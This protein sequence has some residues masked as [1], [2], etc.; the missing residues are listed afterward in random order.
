MGERSN[1]L[2][3][4]AERAAF[5]VSL[6]AHSDRLALATSPSSN[7]HVELS[8]RRR[9]REHAADGG[10]GMSR[11][12]QTSCLGRPRLPRM[13]VAVRSTTDSTPQGF[14]PTRVALRCQVR[15]GA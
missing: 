14:T 6:F 10:A 8:T 15:N 2:R 7:G 9:N 5:V 3:A 12:C 1:D 13:R 11:E 4:L